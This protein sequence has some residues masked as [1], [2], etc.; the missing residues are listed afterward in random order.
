L[1]G[2]TAPV[3]WTV[4]IPPSIKYHIPDRQSKDNLQ[5]VFARYTGKTFTE[6]KQIFLLKVEY[7]LF[8]KVFYNQP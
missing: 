3:Y 6:G 2:L 5:A 1:G 4:Y 7:S 8:R